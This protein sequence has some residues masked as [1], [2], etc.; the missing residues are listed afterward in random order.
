MCALSGRLQLLSPRCCWWLL[1]HDKWAE[2]SSAIGWH[3]ELIWSDLYSSW[4]WVFQ[5]KASAAK[6]LMYGFLLYHETHCW[7]WS[8]FDSSLCSWLMTLCRNWRQKP[9]N[10]ECWT[11]RTMWQRSSSGNR[12]TTRLLHTCVC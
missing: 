4:M 12:K 10:S 8:K 1:W 9:L 7:C 11:R 2:L 5:V 3:C 6:L